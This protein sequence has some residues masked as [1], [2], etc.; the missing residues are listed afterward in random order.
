MTSSSAL[1]AR[2]VAEHKAWLWILGILFAVNVVAVAVGVLPLSRSV[3]A[4]EQ[5]AQTAASDAAAAQAELRD[6]AAARDGRDAAA[7]DLA[8][9]YKDVLPAD[10]GAARRVLQLRV[11]Q[12]ARQ[13]QVTF[14]RS[15]ASPE[16]VRGSELS[17][18]RVSAD[19]VGRYRDI[20]AFLYD[21]ETSDDF[22][23]ID[24]IVLGE[25]DEPSSPL[26][27]TLQV[28]TSYKGGGPRVP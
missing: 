22:V 4:E 12:L 20:R 19:L 3:A 13:H 1:S 7:R 11:A 25:G 27:L 10:V 23:I 5:R 15:V 14:A 8:V 17:R 6:V 16:T 21:L 9:F 26:N 28:S 18:L 2:I 24:S